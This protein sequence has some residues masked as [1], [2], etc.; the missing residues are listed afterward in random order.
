ML[1]LISKYEKMAF[2][3]SFWVDSIDPK[4]PY[5]SNAVPWF[6]SPQVTAQVYS[7]GSPLSSSAELVT[8]VARRLCSLIPSNSTA[9][10]VING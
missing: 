2:I 9:S 1:L 8:R 7:I 4:S 10:L 3:S 6:I 5:H